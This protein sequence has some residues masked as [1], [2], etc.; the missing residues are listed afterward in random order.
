LKTKKVR[1]QIA[2][3]MI[4]RLGE[5]G[6]NQLCLALD[7]IKWAELRAWASKVPVRLRPLPW[8]FKAERR[9]RSLMVHL[10]ARHQKVQG[11]SE[12]RGEKPT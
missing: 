1:K 12:V 3:R 7:A 2:D 11:N 9:Q 6:D 4:E 10:T 5:N 8:G